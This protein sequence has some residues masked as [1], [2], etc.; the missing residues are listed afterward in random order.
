MSIRFHPKYLEILPFIKIEI[1][2]PD[3]GHKNPRF[4]LEFKETTSQQRKEWVALTCPCVNCGSQIHPIRER[5]SGRGGHIY[6][7]PC[8][9]LNQNTGC[10]RGGKA[11]AEYLAIRKDVEAL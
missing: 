10:S 7:A 6:L 8:C 3:G 2:A 9:P 5:R 4:R 1:Y 11:H